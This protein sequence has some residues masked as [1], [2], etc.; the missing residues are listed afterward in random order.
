MCSLI[1]S[2]EKGASKGFPSCKA[3]SNAHDIHSRCT[4]AEQWASLLSFLHDFCTVQ[5]LSAWSALLTCLAEQV[6]GEKEPCKQ[7]GEV[8]E[9]AFTA[10]SHSC[11]GAGSDQDADVRAEQ[12][13][14]GGGHML[15][16]SLFEILERALHE[17]RSL[18]VN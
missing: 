2:R 1:L 13:Q 3:T 12:Q 9:E 15:E 10:D 11:T 17:G 14:E 18:Q 6:W 8:S 4:Q 7:S 5:R 16:V